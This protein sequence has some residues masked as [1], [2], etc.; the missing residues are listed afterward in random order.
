MLADK[1]QKIISM[2]TNIRIAPCFFGFLLC[3]MSANAIAFTTVLPNSFA[4]SIGVSP[5]ISTVGASRTLFA[6][7]CTGSVTLDESE[8]ATTRTL[9]LQSVPFSIGCVESPKALSFT[10]RSVGT[11]RVI[12]K[13]PDGRVAAE[14]LMETVVGAR[15]PINLDGMWFDPATNGSG[16]SFHHAAGS[17][18]VFG[19]WFLYGVSNFSVPR[20]YSLQ[21]MQWMQGGALL[22]GTA[23]EPAGAGPALCTVGDDC[24][25]PAVIKPVGSVSVAVIDRDNLRVEALDQYGRSAFVSSLKR[26]AF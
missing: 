19:T 6:N 5:S 9:I 7:G 15:S 8:V 16:I 2:A 17:D 24:P 14:A 12:M 1:E 23:Y 13:L 21:N 11:L 18:T 20:W 25:R 3:A 10:P 22:V 26:L 4:F